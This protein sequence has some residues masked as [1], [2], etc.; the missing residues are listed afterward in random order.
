MKTMIFAT[1]IIFRLFSETLVAFEF[2]KFRQIRITHLNTCVGEESCEIDNVG[3]FEK[4]RQ[5]AS[6]NDNTTLAAI[7]KIVENYDEC[8]LNGD[9]GCVGQFYI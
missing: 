2:P 6:V 9:D 5:N 8:I 3:E 4:V 1:A 7:Q